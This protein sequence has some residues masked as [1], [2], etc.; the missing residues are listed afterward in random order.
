MALPTQVLNQTENG[1]LKALRWLEIEGCPFAVGNR[2]MPGSFWTGSY[3]YLAMV[4]MLTGKVPRGA[5][6]G[7]DLLEGVSYRPGEMEFEFVDADPTYAGWF[8]SAIATGKFEAAGVPTFLQSALT[9]ASTT[10]NVGTYGSPW[11][12]SGT[13]YIGKETFLWTANSSGSLTGLTRGVYRS[14]AIAHAKGEPATTYPTV[15][16]RRRVWY[17][18]SFLDPTTSTWTWANKM[19]R[20]GGTIVDYSLDGGVFR[21]KVRSGDGDLGLGNASMSPKLFRTLRHGKI[22]DTMGGWE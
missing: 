21:L 10:I 14:T 15:L 6:V 22:L 20:F 19:Y 4:P 13:G 1:D 8:A 12:S 7:F 16:G 18:V 17:Y 11:G 3:S 2:S 5:D 9:N